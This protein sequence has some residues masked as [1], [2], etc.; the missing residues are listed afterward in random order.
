MDTLHICQVKKRQE[1]R[2][3][4]PKVTQ[5]LEKGVISSYIG[6]IIAGET[7]PD[8]PDLA[9]KYQVSE[10]TIRQIR[11]DHGLNRHDLKGQISKHRNGKEEEGS[12]QLHTPYG[13]LWLLIPM[14]VESFIPKVVDVIRMPVGCSIG[15][16][17]VILTLIV[18]FVLGFKRLWHLDDFRSDLG[19]AL[20]TGRGCLLADSSIWRC[21]DQL[22]AYDAFYKQTACGVLSESKGYRI[23]LDDH[24]VPSFTKLSPPPLEKTR[25]PTRGRSY[26]ASRLYYHYDMD[27]N[28]II[29]LSVK[30]AKERLSVVLFDLIGHIRQLKRRAKVANPNKLRLTFDRG[31]YKGSNFQKLL[32]DRDITFLTLAIATAK[33][34]RQ[35]ENIPEEQFQSY[36]GNLKMADTTTTITNCTHPIRSIV[37]RD[38]SEGT[39]QKWRVYLT[40]DKLTEGASLDQEYRSHQHHENAYRVLKYDLSADALPKAYILQRET[41]DKGRKTKTTGTISSPETTKRIH[42]IGWIKALAFN[43]VKSFGKQLGESYSKMHL[44]TLV[45]KFIVKPGIITL[46][47]GQIHVSLE[48]FKDAHILADYIDQINQKDITVPWLGNAK[49]TIEVKSVPQID[50]RKVRRIKRLFFANSRY[51][52]TA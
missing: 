41:N 47:R 48:P 5:E 10:R 14:I 8:D 4:K 6:A 11:L 31:G 35:W 39:K 3:R 50:N 34:V 2:G 27:S 22:C 45:R 16:W 30:A 32:D 29:G 21:V 40:N 44:S 25:I 24:V 52:N 42:L 26:P 20:F 7:M 23:S 43:L 17:H 49:L 36:E 9:T 51:L 15:L 38:D 13:G 33:N 28:R 19:L 18:W 46:Q 1:T 12:L 37:I